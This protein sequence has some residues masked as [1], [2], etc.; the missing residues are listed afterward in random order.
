MYV[1]VKINL[2]CR[3]FFGGFLKM[4]VPL[5]HPFHGIFHYKPTILGTPMAK[6][7]NLQ[8]MVQ[9]DTLPPGV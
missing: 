8:E 1:N 4:G 5:N 2:E 6:P 3:W 7:W 9:V